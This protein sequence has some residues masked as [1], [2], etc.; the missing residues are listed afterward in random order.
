[1]DVKWPLIGEMFGGTQRI[2]PRFQIVASPKIENL[3]VPNEDARAVDLED[4]NLFA[5]N[6]FP[7]Y[8]R[9]EDSTRFTWGVDYA[10]YLPGISVDAN[11]GQSYR[12]TSRPTLF[13]DG[14]GLTDRVSDIVGRTV[15]RFHDFVS[16]THRYRLDKDGLAFRRNEVDATVGSRSTY[17]ELG[18]LRLN[19]NIGPAL[20]DLQDREEA[21]VGARA[22]IARFWSVSGA[23]LID[24]TNREEDPLSQADGFEPVRHRLG[25]AYEDDCLRLGLTWKRDYATT[26]DARRGNSFLL[27][28]AFKNLGR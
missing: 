2:T 7:G 15:I 20:E 5:L 11:V 28:L 26:G 13:P 23:M 22:Q 1:V 21:R 4:S 12:I 6:R 16:L 25:V 9:F 27:S 10:L 18:Y 24:L 17:V 14:T 19:R 8:D 3:S